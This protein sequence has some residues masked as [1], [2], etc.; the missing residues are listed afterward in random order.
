MEEEKVIKSA[1]E[2]YHEMKYELDRL[3]SW[4]IPIRVDDKLIEKV[5][6]ER[7]GDE[8]ILQ[9]KTKN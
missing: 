1:G 7:K 2:F 8:Y 3:I 9:I 5:Y 4:N 6:L